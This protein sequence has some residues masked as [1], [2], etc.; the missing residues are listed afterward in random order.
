[1][2]SEFLRLGYEGIPDRELLIKEILDEALALGP[3]E[4]LLNDETVD[5]IM[6]N[7]PDRIF[8]ERRGKVELTDRK[9]VS[10]QQVYN[11]IE[12][13]VGP[14]GRRVDESSPYVDARLLRDG[15]RVH[16]IVPPLALNGPTIT[17]RIFS[18]KPFSADKLIQ[19]GSLSRNAYRFLDV[20]VKAKKSV[21]VS[22]GTGSGKTTLLN[23]LSSSI[24]EDERIITIEDAAELRLTHLNLVSL[25]S[26]RHNVEGKGEVT[27]RELVRNA[28]RMRPDRI[29]VGECRGPEAF[30]MLQAMN[31]GHEG[32]L[33]TIHANSPEDMLSRLEN[34]VLM[35]VEIPLPVIRR[36]I[37][38]AVN[39]IVQISRYRDGTRK[40]SEI[41]EVTGMDADGIKLQKI[42]EFVETGTDDNGRVM[43]QFRATGYKPA[44]LEEFRIKNFN[45]ED[46]WFEN[47]GSSG[48]EEA[49][50]P[51]GGGDD[52]DDAHRVTSPSDFGP[53]TT[54]VRVTRDDSVTETIGLVITKE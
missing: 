50:Q 48:D 39:L 41:S 17:I 23:I 7:R 10:V 37:S 42:F 43:G 32:S 3:L 11:V 6:V 19:K 26:R 38:S 21:L 31:T 25:E 15:S 13:I 33:T 51:D 12:R 47:N 54:N 24:P 53:A 8:V 30:D 29:I 49:L 40:I 28:L 1:V 2:R 34:L 22:G 45:V 9:F 4:D 52:G 36:N 5:E 44:F 20:C 14:I 16:I 18:R 46:S 27:I 35:A